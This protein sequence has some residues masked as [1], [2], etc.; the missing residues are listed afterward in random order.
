MEKE[1]KEMIKNPRRE[2]QFGTKHTSV[3]VDWNLWTKVKENKISLKDALNFGIR[4]MLSDKIGMDYPECNLKRKL[5]VI[6]K[7]LQAKCNE[8]EALRDQIQKEDYGEDI[9]D[10]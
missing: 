7:K 9:N 3:N 2:M 6:S 4:F 8:C 1:K 5:H 10:Y